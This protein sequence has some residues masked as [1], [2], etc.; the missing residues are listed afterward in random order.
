MGRKD[1]W[2]SSGPTTS[3]VLDY[4]R[5]MRAY[6]GAVVTVECYPT[7]PGTLGSGVMTVRLI[8]APGPGPELA[9]GPLA[10]VSVAGEWPT[11]SHSTFEGLLYALGVRL[12]TKLGQEWW[13]QRELPF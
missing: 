4:W 1:R 11:N 2:V 9:S 8:A 13:K 7:F 3:D 10:P 5:A 12:D 6:H